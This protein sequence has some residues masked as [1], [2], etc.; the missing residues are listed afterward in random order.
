MKQ[1]LEGCFA[2]LIATMLIA[3]I[4]TDAEARIYEDTVRLH[5]LAE[6]DSEEDQQTKLA[7]RDMILAHYGER[8][9]GYETV[10]EA[11]EALRELIWDIEKDVNEWLSELKSGATAEV[12]L[13]REWYDRREY[14]DIALPAGEYLS[15]R[16]IIGEGEGKNWWCVMYPPLCLDVALGDYVGYSEDENRLITVGK[17]NVKMKILELCSTAFKK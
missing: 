8:L 16:V 1:T 13:T 17:Y 10:E 11:E 7:I 2:L 6:S 15:L 12:T 14:G 3:T 4:P 5:I 9:S